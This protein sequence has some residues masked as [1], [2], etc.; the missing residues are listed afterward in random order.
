MMKNTSRF[1]TKI[2]MDS[3]ELITGAAVKTPHGI[4]LVTEVRSKSV[5]TA[6]GEYPVEQLWPVEI[7]PELLRNSCWEY[8]GGYYILRDTPRLGWRNGELILGYSLF[9][10]KVLYVHHLQMIMRCAGISFRLRVDIG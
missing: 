10:L 5:L 9:P 7:T 1:I 6:S 3:S 2:F 8:K 4:E